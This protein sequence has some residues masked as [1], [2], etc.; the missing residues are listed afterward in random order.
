MN[1]QVC[2]KPRRS[3]ERIF[4]ITDNK[5]PFVT[6]PELKSVSYASTFDEIFPPSQTCPVS[7]LFQWFRPICAVTHDWAHNQNIINPLASMP[8][9]TAHSIVR[10]KRFIVWKYARVCIFMHGRA[11]CMAKHTL[12]MYEADVENTRIRSAIMTKS[13]IDLGPTSHITCLSRHIT[14]KMYLKT[15]MEEKRLVD[16]I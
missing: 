4:W 13:A 10:N 14:Y 15:S 7:C 11:H 9:N 5:A 16:L 2:G 8:K 1:E 3:P 6:S 12:A